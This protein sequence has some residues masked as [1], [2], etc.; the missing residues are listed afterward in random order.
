MARGTLWNIAGRVLTLLVA[1]ATTPFL[2]AATLVLVACRAVMTWAYWRLR[3]AVLPGLRV[4]RPDSS[5]AGPLLRQGGWITVS[6]L[7][8]PLAQHLDRFIIQ[9]NRL[10]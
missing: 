7:L 5:A 6:A 2:V 8:G 3:T 4:A 10:N 1:L 9:G